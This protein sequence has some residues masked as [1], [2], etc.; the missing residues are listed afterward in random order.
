MPPKYAVTDYTHL[1]AA[2]A[3]RELTAILTRQ[4]RVDGRRG[5]AFTPTEAILCLAAMRR[6]DYR[7]FGGSTNH[8]APLPVPE[9]SRLFQRTPASVLA[10]MANLDG[11][12]ANGGGNE[13]EAAAVMLSAG[14]QGLEGAYR[15]ILSEARYLGIRDDVLPDFLGLLQA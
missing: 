4:P 12:R 11:A 8:Q 5:P 7:H 14:G 13:V 10:K 15:T 2:Q 1:S 3:R 9:L 6:V